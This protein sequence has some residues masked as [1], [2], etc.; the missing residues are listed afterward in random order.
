[1]VTSSRRLTRGVLALLAA[2]ALLTAAATSAAGAEWRQF[3]RD[4]AHSGFNPD[5]TTLGVG[6]AADLEL[7]WSADTGGAV[8][9]SGPSIANGR[10]SSR[11]TGGCRPSTRRPVTPSGTGPSRD[12]LS[13]PRRRE[14]TGV[15]PHERRSGSGL[16]ELGREAVVVDADGRRYRRAGRAGRDRL[17]WRE[18]AGVRPE[19]GDRCDRVERG[20]ALHAEPPERGRRQSLRGGRQPSRRSTRRR[21]R[22]SGSSGS[23]ACRSRLRW[24]P[25]TGS[26]WARRT[27]GCTACSQVAARSPGMSASDV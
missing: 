23:A 17:R 20:S 18:R 27:T 8:M 19:R 26:T 24:S 13:L 22:G 21:A 6:N 12:S 1:M 11:R 10:C 25:A 3:H 4:V 5:E 7:K 2:S 9:L 16:P 14:R 15:H